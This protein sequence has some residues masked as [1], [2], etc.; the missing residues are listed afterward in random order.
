MRSGYVVDT[1]DGDKRLHLKGR[2][3][4]GSHAPTKRNGSRRR[5]DVELHYSGRAQRSEIFAGDVAHLQQIGTF[6]QLSHNNRL[7]AGDNG[8]ALRSLWHDAAVKGKV[9][10]IYIDPPFATGFLFA[11]TTVGSAYDDDVTGAVYLENLRQRLLM[12]YDLLADDG[13]FYIHLDANAVFHAKLLLDEIFG[14]DRFRNMITRVKCNPKNQ[15]RRQYGDVCDYLLFY[16]KSDEY[17]WNDPLVLWEAAAGEKEYGCVEASTGRRFKK[18]PCHLP[19]VRNGATGQP[20]RG[21]LPPAGKHWV[22]APEDLDELDRQG[23]IYWS[24]NGN[25]RRKIY[26]DEVQGK[27]RQNL[28]MDFR[29]TQNQ[30]ARVTGY[31]TEKNMDMVRMIIEASSNP[32]DLV[33]DAYCGSGTTLAAAGML[34]RAWIGIDSS[35][36]AIETAATRL[37]R[38]TPRM[39]SY[40]RD[41]FIRRDPQEKL[42]HADMSFSLWADAEYEEVGNKIVNKLLTI[43]D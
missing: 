15:V 29:D 1:R 2:M 26:L 39:G 42:P 37:V 28:W 5:L 12:L 33:L 40:A 36:V 3:A 21:K 20:W 19:G 25:P 10:L 22:H 7:I 16:T 27:R 24:A 11:S 4:T 32:D 18:V 35:E 6:G 38:G 17:V 43:E 23:R 31:P 9:K 13:S 30:N 34:G 14:P 41:T 8:R